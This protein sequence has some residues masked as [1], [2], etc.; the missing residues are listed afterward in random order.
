V[1]PQSRK[2]LNEHGGGGGVE[3]V[4]ASVGWE[5]DLRTGGIAEKLEQ[6]IYAHR[7]KGT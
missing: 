5:A 7:K 4:G 1:K 6:N 3:R 2:A